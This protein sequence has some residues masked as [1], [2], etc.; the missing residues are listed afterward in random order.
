MD[1]A[2]HYVPLCGRILAAEKL[3]A[4]AKPQTLATD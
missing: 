4:P 3:A 2:Y 1:G